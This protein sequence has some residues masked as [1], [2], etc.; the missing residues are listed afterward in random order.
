MQQGT[1]VLF[2]ILFAFG[3]LL[4]S[5]GIN[6]G[7]PKRPDEQ[8]TPKVVDTDNENDNL[9]LI[10]SHF[11]EAISSVF[12]SVL[13][14]NT[15]E[16][17][18][19]VFG[20]A[21]TPGLQT[22]E[23]E[24]NVGVKNTVRCSRAENGDINV[25]VDKNG[26]HRGGK[27]GERKPGLKQNF[28][29][30]VQDN[31]TWSGHSDAIT[32]TSPTAVAMDWNKLQNVSISIVSSNSFSRSRSRDR[33]KGHKSEITERSMKID[34]KKLAHDQATGIIKVEQVLDFTAS[35]TR[36]DRNIYRKGNSFSTS[37]SLPVPLK[38]L[39]DFTP[40]DNRWNGITVV[41]GTMLS[42]NTK[43]KSVET[44]Y[45]NLVLGEKGS[46]IPLSGILE[47]SYK[48]EN[49]ETK[50]NFQIE[51]EGGEAYPVIGGKRFEALDP[52]ACYKKPFR[53][54]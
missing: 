13:A 20:A 14:F 9:D 35:K 28:V 19:V 5:C 33:G 7:N 30:N 42:A 46:C 11:D 32:C 49:S 26:S 21:N 43:G 10:D 48:E 53:L 4:G 15:G 39:G 52:E 24:T 23:T 54:R 8:D 40:A 22:S 1:T 37:I 18:K 3:L 34:W 16:I 45:E 29:V 12:D 27:R 17:N 36:A 47:G 44:S 51:F 2:T 25:I 50:N 41:S 31:I 38:I 6:V